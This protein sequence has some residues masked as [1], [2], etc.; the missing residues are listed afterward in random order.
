MLKKPACFV[1]TKVFEFLLIFN[2]IFCPC[3]LSLVTN[4]TKFIQ[5]LI[6]SF[7]CPYLYWMGKCP[8]AQYDKKCSIEKK[9]RSAIYE[10][11][12]DEIL[13]LVQQCILF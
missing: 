3:L 4:G 6:Y 11:G 2:L 7:E 8:R 9:R 1:S 5:V 13:L 10:I 12:K